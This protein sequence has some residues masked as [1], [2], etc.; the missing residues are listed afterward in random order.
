MNDITKAL[1]LYGYFKIKLKSR[2]DLK[3]YSHQEYSNGIQIKLS[4]KY[5][6]ADYFLLY[7]SKQRKC[8]VILKSKYGDRDNMN[9]GTYSKTEILQIL[10]KD[11]LSHLKDVLIALEL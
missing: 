6:P 5:S 10:R 7:P 11:N 4:R 1:K 9:S 3:I 2:K 8:I